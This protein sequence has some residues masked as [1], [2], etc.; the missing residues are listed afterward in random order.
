MS[1]W[2]VCVYGFSAWHTVV[3]G[4]RSHAAWQ[5]VLWTSLL[6]I[7]MVP[8][9]EEICPEH[10]RSGR[11]WAP[12]LSCCFIASLN[13]PFWSSQHTLNYPNVNTVSFLNFLLLGS[14]SENTIFVRQVN[15]PKPKEYYDTYDLFQ[16]LKLGHSITRKT[17]ISF[18]AKFY[19]LLILFHKNVI[20]KKMFVFFFSF[21][22][23]YCTTGTRLFNLNAQMREDTVMAGADGEEPRFG[24]LCASWGLQ[25]PLLWC[26]TGL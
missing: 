15:T 18:S 5:H 9:T 23:C 20:W 26:S 10:L 4:L 16:F 3:A 13:T 11:H 2:S 7:L 22:S 25:E 17:F 8:L 14:K 24:G 6:N 21:H 19:I 1:A 12:V